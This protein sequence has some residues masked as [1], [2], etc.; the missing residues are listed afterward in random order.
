MVTRLNRISLR[1]S[2]Y[3]LLADMS[4]RS[5]YRHRDPFV[6]VLFICAVCMF[7]G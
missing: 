6:V 1:H 5:R 3:D 2:L 4:G 7:V